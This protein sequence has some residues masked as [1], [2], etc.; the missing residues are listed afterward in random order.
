MKRDNHI[1]E[2]NYVL[3]SEGHR[4][5]RDNGSQDIEELGSAVELMG[6]MDQTEE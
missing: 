2:E 5:T 6:F 4:E 3:V 1:L